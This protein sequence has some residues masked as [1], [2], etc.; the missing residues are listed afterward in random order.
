MMG[1]L[2]DDLL[3]IEIHVPGSNQMVEHNEV[4]LSL[5]GFPDQA[6]IK[7][8]QVKQPLKLVKRKKE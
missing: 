1:E 5:N 2:I 6:R 4:L 8:V 7:I 3:H